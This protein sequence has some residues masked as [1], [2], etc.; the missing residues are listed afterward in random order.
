[1]RLRF[2]G[3]FILIFLFLVSGKAYSL[4]SIC[5]CSN[6]DSYVNEN[7]P[8]SNYGKI[9]YMSIYDFRKRIIV[10]FEINATLNFKKIK[11]AEVILTL[12][13]NTN[14]MPG[15][16][17]YRHELYLTLSNWSESEISW[18]NMPPIFEKVGFCSIP[19]TALYAGWQCKINITQWFKSANLSFPINLSFWLIGNN[20]HTHVEYKYSTK[21]GNPYYHPKLIIVYEGNETT[22]TTSTT[23]TTSTTTTTP[24]TSSTT[25]TST[26]ST[27]LTTTSTTTTVSTTTTLPQI[28]KPIILTNDDFWN[29]LVASSTLVPVLVQEPGNDFITD[30]INS[31]IDRYEP[32]HLLCI[33]TNYSGCVQIQPNQLA[34]IFS[35][36]GEVIV[37]NDKEKALLGGFVASL[38]NYSLRLITDIDHNDFAKTTVCTFEFGGCNISLTTKEELIDFIFNLSRNKELNTLIIANVAKNYSALSVRYAKDSIPIVISV[39]ENYSGSNPKF[40]NERN[41]IFEIVKEINKTIERMKNENMIGEDYLLNKTFFLLIFGAPYGLVKDPYFELFHDLDGAYLFTDNFYSDYNNDGYLDLATGRFCCHSSVVSLQ[42]ENRRF[43]NPRRK[44]A[45]I[46][47][48]YRIPRDKWGFD[49]MSDGMITEGTLRSAGFNVSRLVEYRASGWGDELEDLELPDPEEMGIDDWLDFGETLFKVVSEWKYKLYEYDLKDLFL[50]KEPKRLPELTIDNF[51]EN[52][53][54]APLI[55]YF[56]MGNSSNWFFPSEESYDP[57]PTDESLS[58]SQFQW[59]EPKILIDDHSLSGH[60]DS[61]FL[62]YN[63]LLLLG[64]SGIV[65]DTI[66]SITFR[67]FLKPLAKGLPIGEALRNMKRFASVY[68]NEN[69][70]SLSS[71]IFY[72][73]HKIALKDMYQKI[74]YGDPRISID[75]INFE[76]ENYDTR[77]ENGRM[78]IFLNLTPAFEILNQTN[79]TDINVLNADDFLFEINQPLVPVIEK[80]VVLPS[81]IEGYEINYSVS[82]VLELKVK[83]RLLHPDQF[84]INNSLTFSHFPEKNFWVD[85]RDLIDNR[86]ELIIRF[87]P[88]RYTYSNSTFAEVYRA[89][90][91]ISYTSPLEILKIHV[92]NF[93]Q[94]E[95]V[96]INT[97][98]KSSGTAEVILQ[99]I[100]N[101]SLSTFRKNVSILGIQNVS[102]TLNLSPGKYIA[103]VVASYNEF[104]AGPKEKKFEIKKSV[105]TTTTLP[106][107]TISFSTLKKIL[108]IKKGVKARRYFESVQHYIDGEKESF[109]FQS[110]DKLLKIEISKDEEKYSFITPEY[111]LIIIKTPIKSS[112]IFSTS[113]GSA[114]VL[115]KGG[116]RKEIFYGN[117][118][119]TKEKLE[120]ALREFE[121]LITKL[122]ENY[123][124]TF[125]FS[126]W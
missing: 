91:T 95:Q 119:E 4:T 113:S 18:N 78:I 77:E 48:E 58:P 76:V 57:Y 99:V 64:S 14:L 100:G 72:R 83:P 84:S 33:G 122:K 47:A 81:G 44:K 102:F 9:E 79:Y 125:E 51:L 43:W 74:I 36:S 124:Y 108:G 22:T 54:F 19:N 49:G 71:L 10:N 63:N 82:K 40:I 80:V 1:M 24:T 15:I 73:D 92:R 34:N 38:L 31:F 70:S 86:K 16:S 118:Y 61:K 28:E 29:I 39:E 94:D 117:Q 26:T 2:F 115:K 53:E 107:K 13:Y 21:E 66:S 112:S 20:A 104:V 67:N 106:E 27:T 109:I 41:Q 116:K 105:V 62:N 98:I 5:F 93:T 52:K 3:L 7:D 69:Y 68:E 101:N 114:I 75:P 6:K 65:H 97:E 35:P 8:S 32:T 56:G 126:F 121:E 37:D 55:F 90:A 59:K 42:I 11:H 17:N 85:V 120:R 45:L 89:E 30:Q 88:V 96:T 123:N 103:K 87:A 25:S 12:A 110:I 60:K 50:L 111:S 46:L 23:S